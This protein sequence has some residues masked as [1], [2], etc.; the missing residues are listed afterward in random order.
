[1]L[2]EFT[3]ACS[4][5][6]CNNPNIQATQLAVSEVCDAVDTRVR[7]SIEVMG[8]FYDFQNVAHK[9]KLFGYLEL[10]QYYAEEVVDSHEVKHA[11]RCCADEVPGQ[12]DQWP[13]A[14]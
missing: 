3:T 5:D 2:S 14:P 11:V 7:L 6:Q 8:R 4:D 10:A 1:M 12:D 13:K 9:M